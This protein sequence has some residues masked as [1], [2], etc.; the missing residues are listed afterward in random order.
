MKN[1]IVIH[2][3][4]SV[5]LLEENEHVDFQNFKRLIKAPFIISGDFKCALI[6]SLDN[7]DFGPNTKRYQSYFCSYGYKLICFH[8]RY[9]KPYKTYFD[10]DDIDRFLND[11]IKEGEYCSKV[12]E[13]KFNKLLAMTEKIMKT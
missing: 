12:I 2:Y 4:K 5:L 9:S 13:T 8:D 10:E 6:P 11:M 3:T 7:I 1:C